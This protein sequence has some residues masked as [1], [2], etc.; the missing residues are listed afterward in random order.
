MAN[1]KTWWT[2]GKPVV[3]TVG[4]LARTWKDDREKELAR[5]FCRNFYKVK[6]PRRRIP[7][8]KRT[9]LPTIDRVAAA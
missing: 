8:M 1:A 3:V 9:A 4:D 5:R 6:F 7:I 2:D